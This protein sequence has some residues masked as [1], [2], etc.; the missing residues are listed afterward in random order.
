MSKCDELKAYHVPAEIAGGVVLA[1]A[2]DYYDRE[3]VD[4]AIAELKQKLQD[5]LLEAMKYKAENIELLAWKKLRENC[6]NYIDTLEQKLHDAEEE[7]HNWKAEVTR[8]RNEKMALFDEMSK[9]VYNE[10]MRADLAEA[11]ETER[12]IDYDNLKAQM[13]K[14]N[15]YLEHEKFKKELVDE[16]DGYVYEWKGK[17]FIATPYINIFI[18]GILS[19]LWLARAERAKDRAMTCDNFAYLGD[20]E[21]DMTM[22]LARTWMKCR[23]LK[24]SEWSKVWQ[25]VERLCRAKAEEYK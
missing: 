6:D 8:V 12:K 17:E 11:A 7:L 21:R 4:E 19:A 23:L 13:P 2:F 3:P 18:K 15:K 1:E 10:K 20:T 24:P 16:Y 9:K 5:K 22:A 14:Y 25:K